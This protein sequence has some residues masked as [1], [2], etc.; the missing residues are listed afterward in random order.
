[1]FLRSFWFRTTSRGVAATDEMHIYTLGA[2]L[3]QLGLLEQSCSSFPHSMLAASALSLALVFFGKET[4]P[5]ELSTFGSYSVDELQPCRSRLAAGAANQ[6]ARNLRFLWHSYC[7]TH[8]YA[9]FAGE[10]ARALSIVSQ[11]SDCISALL[12]ANGLEPSVPC[13]PPV[14]RV[15]SM[16][17]P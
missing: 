7:K 11:P 15:P 4:W 5:K 2:F 3:L 14:Q 1:M 13:N 16:D 12:G 6:E 8:D 10:W 17:T 9:S